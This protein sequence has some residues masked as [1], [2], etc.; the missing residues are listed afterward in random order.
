MRSGRVGIK[1]FRK[2]QR[3]EE[4]SEYYNKSFSSG[5]VLPTFGSLIV[6]TMDLSDTNISEIWKG[7]IEGHL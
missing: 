4:Q 2:G 5:S 6:P 1:S 7:E 3:G